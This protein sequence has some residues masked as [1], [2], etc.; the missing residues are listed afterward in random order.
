MGKA[1]EAAKLITPGEG[2][3][4]GKGQVMLQLQ[5]LFSA[6]RATSD[7]AKKAA[8]HHQIIDVM[9]TQENDKEGWA[10]DVSA[11]SKFPN[12]AVEE[13]GSSSDPFEKWLLAAVLLARHDEANAA[14]Y[15]VEAGASGKYPKAYKFS[16]DIYLR[17]ERHD[18]VEAVLRKMPERSG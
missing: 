16:A 1:D 11:A 6:E 3:Q 9:K 15:Y 8:Y 14:K 2:G 18:P 4:K 17:E 5:T 13:F 12:N 7:P 10:I